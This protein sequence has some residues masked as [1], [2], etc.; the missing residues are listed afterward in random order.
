M[1]WIYRHPRFYDVFD[2]L[3]SMSLSDRVRRRVLTGLKVRRLL[4][5][6]VGSGKGLVYT[7]SGFS[8]GL[9]RA[10]DMLRRAKSRFPGTNMIMADAHRLPFEDGSIDVSLFTFCLAVLAKPLEAISEA[11]RVSSKVIVIDYDRPTVIPG[12]AWRS[13]CAKLGRSVFGS[14]DVDFE[15]VKA[16]AATSE[17]RTYYRNL[18][19]IVVLSGVTDAGS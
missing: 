18:Y 1:K 15:S 14:R 6:G 12:T 17:G 4:E 7:E 10:P 11:L 13:V 2:S 5:I 16:L 19:R 8:I 3:I 9:D